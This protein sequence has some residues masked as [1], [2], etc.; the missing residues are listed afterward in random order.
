MLNIARKNELITTVVSTSIVPSI[1][2]GVAI[3]GCILFTIITELADGH[4][5]PTLALFSQHVNIFMIPL[6]AF[7]IYLTLIW[8]G[9]I[10]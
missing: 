8:G 1:V 5:R 9:K 7:F 6:L 2:T 3:I 4:K 10:I